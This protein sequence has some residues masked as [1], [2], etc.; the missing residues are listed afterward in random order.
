MEVLAEAEAS[1]VEDAVAEDEVVVAV[2]VLVDEGAA[3]VLQAAREPARVRAVTEDAK[4]IQNR[5]DGERVEVVIGRVKGPT[6]S[7]A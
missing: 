2:S 3:D 1:A 6:L 4:R 7:L 5:R